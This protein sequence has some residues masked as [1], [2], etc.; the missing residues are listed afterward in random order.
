M[1]GGVGACMEGVHSYRHQ[2]WGQAGIVPRALHED[3]YGQFPLQ[4]IQ[5]KS[6]L[7]NRAERE[8]GLAKDPSPL[9]RAGGT[10]LALT[11]PGVQTGTRGWVWR[12]HS[13][14]PSCTAWDQSCT[15]GRQEGQ[16]EAVRK[17][18]C[19]D[20]T[21]PCSCR[22]GASDNPSGPSSIQFLGCKSFPLSLPKHL[23]PP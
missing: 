10:C 3:N 9:P 1:R 15:E 11:G 14:A 5:L 6:H 4:H 7:S 20:S 17:D 23:L 2:V 12:W 18:R 21:A 16:R 19:A 8:E 13:T 22:D